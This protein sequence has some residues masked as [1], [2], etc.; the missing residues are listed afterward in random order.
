MDPIKKDLMFQP[1]G[2]KKKRN[3]KHSAPKK[4]DQLMVN[5]WF[6]SFSGLDSGIPL[7]KGLLL[8][9][10]FQ[11]PVKGGRDYITP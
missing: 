9:W 1:T 2:T 11:V 3:Q 8:Q 10:I 7:R 6:G 5:C 4:A